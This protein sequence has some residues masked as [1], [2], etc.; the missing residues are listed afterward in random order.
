MVLHP[1]LA[2]VDL[3]VRALLVVHQACVARLRLGHLGVEQRAVEQ[4]DHQ[5]GVEPD[6]DRHRLVQPARIDRTD[7]WN[8]AFE[9]AHPQRD[10]VGDGRGGDLDQAA[11][12]PDGRRRVGRGLVLQRQAIGAAQPVI[13]I[14]LGVFD[15]DHRTG[16]KGDLDLVACEVQIGQRRGVAQ[17]QQVDHPVAQAAQRCLDAAGRCVTQPQPCQLGAAPLGQK[18]AVHRLEPGQRGGV[19]PEHA[20]AQVSRRLVTH[21]LLDEAA[22]VGVGQTPS[23][24]GKDKAQAQRVGV[25]GQGRTQQRQA[26]GGAGQLVG[27]QGAQQDVLDDMKALVGCAQAK[28]ARQ[29]QGQ[30]GEVAVGGLAQQVARH[31]AVVADARQAAQERL[32][33]A[34]QHRHGRIGAGECAVGQQ[35]GVV[36]KLLAKACQQVV[37]HPVAA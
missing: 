23:V 35:Q 27:R 6:L 22:E 31:A 5:R 9:R 32:L 1:L 17:S 24:A 30:A 20:Q 25:A 13:D 36:G 28:A 26:S 7:S 34:H 14:G 29:A 16:T 8:I 33:V 10:V 2:G 3:H 19:E 21:A 37:Q 15:A 4:L 11:A 12:A 18:A